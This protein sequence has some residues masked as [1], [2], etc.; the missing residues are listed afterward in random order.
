VASVDS[1]STIERTSEPGVGGVSLVSSD[2]VVP[3]EVSAATPPFM[4]RFT[5]DAVQFAS[6]NAIDPDRSV[7]AYLIGSK[8]SATRMASTDV[9]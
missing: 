6:A 7:V 1:H 3:V 9:E 4:A 5:L 2:P 8:N